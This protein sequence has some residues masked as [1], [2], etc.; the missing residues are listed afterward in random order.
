MCVPF[1]H[2]A[3]TRILSTNHMYIFA[4]MVSIYHGMP[5]GWTSDFLLFG[6]FLEARWVTMP[7]TAATAPRIL[8]GKRHL[9]HRPRGPKSPPQQP[10]RRVLHCAAQPH[11]LQMCPLLQPPVELLRV[12]TQSEHFVVCGKPLLKRDPTSA[13]GSINHFSAWPD[14]SEHP[15]PLPLF[16]HRSY[17]VDRFVNPD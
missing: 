17:I 12:R 3:C 8:L 16:D 10:Q 2:F 14:P 13:S 9:Q 4:S 5:D 7:A 1:H 15:S 6:F 11:W